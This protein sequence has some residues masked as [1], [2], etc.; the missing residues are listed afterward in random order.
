MVAL[1]KKIPLGLVEMSA[2][3]ERAEQ[4]RDGSFC[5]YRPVLPLMLASFIFDVLCTPGVLAASA[6]GSL[7]AALEVP[8]TLFPVLLQLYLRRVRVHQAETATLSCLETRSWASRLLWLLWVGRLCPRL[9]P[10]LPPGLERRCVCRVCAGMKTTVSE[11]EHPL[12]CEGTRR[13][14]GDLALALMITYKDDQCKLK[15]VR[16]SFAC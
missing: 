14:K 10:L 3:R 2:I 6:F 11:A 9:R 13:V 15:K 8:L 12:L 5:D 4:L 16:R 7:A 1:L